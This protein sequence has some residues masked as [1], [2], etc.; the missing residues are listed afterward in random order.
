MALIKCPE[1]GHQISDKAPVCPSCGVEIAGKIVRCPNCGE[2]HFIS[3]GICPNC[4]HSLLATGNDSRSSV[5]HEPSSADSSEDALAEEQ[6]IAE[7]ENEIAE[8]ASRQK[9]QESTAEPVMPGDSADEEP[10]SAVPLTN[11]TS[12]DKEPVRPLTDSGMAEAHPLDSN[13]AGDGP[14]K[15]AGTSKVNRR[16]L[17][18]SLIVAAVIC[19]VVLFLY[20]NAKQDNENSE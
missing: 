3:D 9:T 5:A 18:I 7:E 15:P 16:S 4:H 13:K 14:K 8:E 1:C 17:I 20:S 10:I 12:G 11:A 2:I 6:A 19:L